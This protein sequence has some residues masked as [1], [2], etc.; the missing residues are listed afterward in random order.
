M[1]DAGPERLMQRSRGR[2]GISFALRD[3]AV[4]LVDL[5]QQGSAKAMLPR[6]AG[7]VPE[8]VFLNTSGGLT[9]GDALSYAIEVGAGARVTATTQTAERAYSSLGAQARMT[10]SAR[11]GAGG[12]LDWLPQETILYETAHLRRDTIIDL[13]ADAS[14]LLVESVVLGRQAMGERPAIAQLSDNRRVNRDGKPVWVER[15]RIDQHFLR[16]SENPA[17]LSGA[18]AFAVVALV[19]PGAEDALNPVRKV[20]DEAGC[21]AAASGWDGKCLVRVTAGDGWPLKRQLA[22]V[23]AVLSGRPLPRVWQ[24]QGVIP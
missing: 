12:R 2:A 23:L 1:L 20:L 7:P 10:V 19:A 21:S 15:Q 4:R 11:V 22:R 17:L 24:M 8:V 14:C 5:H 16:D 3:G 9:G 18:R 13:A 6:V